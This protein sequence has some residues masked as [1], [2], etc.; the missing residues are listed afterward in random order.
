MHKKNFFD[1]FKSFVLPIRTVLFKV[2]GC[3]ANITLILILTRE[4]IEILRNQVVQ[5]EPGRRQNLAGGRLRDFTLT[6]TVL[7]AS[8]IGVHNISET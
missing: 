3:L 2:Y 1:K 8:W 7:I 4:K 5:C 6:K